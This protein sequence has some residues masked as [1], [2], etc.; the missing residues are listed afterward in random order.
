MVVKRVFP[1]VRTAFDFDTAE[2]DPGTTKIYP[3]GVTKQSFADECDINQIMARYE[4]TGVIDHVTTKVP[5]WGD[6]VSVPDFHEAMNIVV[7]SEE[8][9]A[10]LDAHTRD[11][12]G[13]DPAQML[14]F[15]NDPANRDEAVKLGLVE[16]PKPADPPLKVEVVSDP[17]PP[18]PGGGVAASGDGTSPA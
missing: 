10:A 16:A 18:K 15:L 17:V 5:Q 12:F 14:A 7:K 3:D 13:N 4:K 1:H 9:F 11:R 6:V 2:Y 8:L